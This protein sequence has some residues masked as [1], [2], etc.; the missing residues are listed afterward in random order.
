MRA[1]ECQ[2]QCLEIPEFS[3]AGVVS[4][5]KPHASRRMRTHRCRAGILATR[6]PSRL[7]LRVL[8][9]RRA[10]SK[11]PQALPQT[12]DCL[13]K[14]LEM[15]PLLLQQHHPPPHSTSVWKVFQTLTEI[16]ASVATTAAAAATAPAAPARSQS[17]DRQA[18]EGLVS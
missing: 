1:G 12:L 11:Q 16:F 3:L 2:W 18:G 14:F 7:R 6:P 17:H 10:R 13:Y 8:L 15:Y 9:I 4:L 5:T